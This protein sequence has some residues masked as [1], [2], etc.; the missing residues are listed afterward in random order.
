MK[1]FTRS[2]QGNL[3]Q[4]HSRLRPMLLKIGLHDNK[5]TKILPALAVTTTTRNTRQDR[6]TAIIR[7]HMKDIQVLGASD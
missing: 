6:E 7:E 1:Q 4:N 2:L 3:S 5:K